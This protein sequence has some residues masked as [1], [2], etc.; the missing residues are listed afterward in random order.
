MVEKGGKVYA[1]FSLICTTPNPNGVEAYDFSGKK[2]KRCKLGHVIGK[3]EIVSFGS[4]MNP[5]SKS[6]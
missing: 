2:H 4:D 5:S 3:S 1:R 6:F